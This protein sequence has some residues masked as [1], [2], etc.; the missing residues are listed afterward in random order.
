MVPETGSCFFLYMRISGLILLGCVAYAFCKS[1]SV[2]HFRKQFPDLVVSAKDTVH[3]GPDDHRR[4][5]WNAETIRFYDLVLRGGTTC[6]PSTIA[7]EGGFI[8]PRYKLQIGGR[9]AYIVHTGDTSSVWVYSGKETVLYISNPV[10]DKFEPKYILASGHAGEG[11]W[12]ETDSWITDLN[13]DGKIDIISRDIGEWTSQD[14]KGEFISS[15]QDDIRAVTWNDTG[16]VKLNLTNDD[17][18]KSIYHNHYYR[19]DQ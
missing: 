12:S 2:D 7:Q 16:F 3:F 18:L 14:E 19:N 4:E 1:P 15:A 11:P 9:E 13:N 6:T 5:L 10:T 17:S 8:E